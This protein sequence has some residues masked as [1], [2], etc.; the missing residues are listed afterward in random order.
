MA[1]RISI[2]VWDDRDEA[3]ARR[4]RRPLPD[5]RIAPGGL[6]LADLRARAGADGAV[7]MPGPFGEDRA[8][9]PLSHWAED[10]PEHTMLTIG[11]ES[12]APPSPGAEVWRPPPP[13]ADLQALL[14]ELHAL[15]ARFRGADEAGRAELEPLIDA[16][17]ERVEA[18]PAHL[19]RR[20]R[21]GDYVE[22]EPGI[23]VWDTRGG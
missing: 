2:R 9:L 4:F 18:H 15:R 11:F 10:D 23:R 6:R 3:A 5:G 14:D 19:G 13:P 8:R 22:V 16:Q 21:A 1:R 12:K 20:E 17:W 7:R